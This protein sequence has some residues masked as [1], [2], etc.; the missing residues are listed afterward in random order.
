MYVLTLF[1]QVAIRFVDVTSVEKAKILGSI[2]NSIEICTQHKKYFWA[3]FLHRDKAFSMIMDRWRATK[4]GCLNSSA[5]SPSGGQ[6][7]STNSNSNSIASSNNNSSSSSNEDTRLELG[8]DSLKMRESSPDLKAISGKMTTS[9]SSFTPNLSK[10]SQNQ[11]DV[12]RHA[13]K[14]NS[15]IS[16]L[17]NEE[18][19]AVIRPPVTVNCFHEKELSNVKVTYKQVFPLSVHDFYLHFISDMGN[20]FWEEFHAKYDYKEFEMSHWKTSDDKCCIERTTQFKAPKKVGIVTK[21][22]RVIQEQRCRYDKDNLIFETNTISKDVPYSSN[23]L[24]HAKWVFS[25]ISESSSELEINTQVLFSGGKNLIKSIIERQAIDGCKDWFEYWVS[26]SLAVSDLLHQNNKKPRNQ[27]TPKRELLRESMKIPLSSIKPIIERF[28]QSTDYSPSLE[29]RKKSISDGIDLINSGRSSG[30]SGRANSSEEQGSL[31]R[32]KNGQYE[33]SNDVA[34]EQ[35]DN[36]KAFA[37]NYLQK[38]A[39]FVQNQLEPKLLILGTIVVLALIII[40]SLCTLYFSSSSSSLE[41]RFGI[42]SQENKNLEEQI[43]FIRSIAAKAAGKKPL[44]DTLEHWRF[45]QEQG[46]L[47]T[48]IERWKE[49]ATT[50]VSEANKLADQLRTFNLPRPKGGDP[51]SDFYQELEQYFLAKTK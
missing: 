15:H 11:I 24:V 6:H 34:N 51:K 45:W 9:T 32:N 22:T 47:D 36:N 28:D 29:D 41:R 3:S 18:I 23:F 21:Y 17:S 44:D 49:S 8:D 25:P 42:L 46:L 40:L 48:I 37:E 14:L 13:F 20:S 19:Q 43:Q 12:K 50:L 2:P 33:Y 7:G 38:Y 16:M 27:R 39:N 35:T 4:E 30:V 5:P 10:A 1:F 26:N 31:D